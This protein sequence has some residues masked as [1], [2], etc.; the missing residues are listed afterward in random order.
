MKFL[1][2]TMC[3]VTLII[4][5]I[6]GCVSNNQEILIED[7][8]IE[9]IKEAESNQ[10]TEEETEV[11]I[12]KYVTQDPTLYEGMEYDEVDIDVYINNDLI[13][14]VVYKNPEYSDN[15]HDF[16]LAK[17]I[18]EYLSI[19]YYFGED[20]GITLT[21]DKYGTTGTPEVS[22]MRVIDDEL[23]I[24]F[25]LLNAH[26]KGSLK[27]EDSSAVYLY[28]CDFKRDDLPATL[29]ECYKML[30]EELDSE[31]IE[32]IKYSTETDRID[33]HFGLGMWIRNEWLYPTQSKLTSLLYESGVMH[34]DDMSAIII[35]GYY[36]YLNGEQCSLEDLILWYYEG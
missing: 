21:S 13:D 24:M 10:F 26:T 8:N 3:F 20:S 5:A 28:T 22:D 18:F 34:T 27:Q 36:R 17:P 32:F 29:E 6:T 33:M 4:F 12:V 7:S 30:D 2:I 19:T 1:I 16:V 35:E 23:Y 25:S 31:D 11:R 14:A 9:N 15:L